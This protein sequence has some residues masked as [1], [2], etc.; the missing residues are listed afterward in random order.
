MFYQNVMPVQPQNL[1][2]SYG[3]FK[4]SFEKVITNP[5]KREDLLILAKNILAKK[6]EIMSIGL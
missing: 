3:E 2:R 6:N 4:E 1:E 5:E